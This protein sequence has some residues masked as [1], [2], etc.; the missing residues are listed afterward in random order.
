MFVRPALLSKYFSDSWHP[1]FDPETDPASKPPADPPADPAK[2]APS[3][4]PKGRTVPEGAVVFES[5]D[6]FE[7]ALKERLERAK[8]SAATAAAEEEAVKQ[9]DFRKI[10]TEQYT[11]LKKEVEEKL[12]PELERWRTLAQEEVTALQTSLP[13][14]LKDLMPTG[15]ALDAQ[16]EWLR[17]AKK[18]AGDQ[19]DPKRGNDPKDPDP[20]GTSATQALEKLKQTMQ[21]NPIY[22]SIR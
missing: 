12:N 4:P 9:G 6:A 3:S 16:L 10:V 5:Q 1:H 8:A 17:K 14:N 21:L 18:A 19:K 11:P 20:K 22:Q 2:P 15:V 13:D 7:A